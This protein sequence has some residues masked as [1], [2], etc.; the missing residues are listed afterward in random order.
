MQPAM[1]VSTSNS[2]PNSFPRQCVWE[3]GKR[4]P[5]ARGV[6]NTRTRIETGCTDRKDSL[7]EKIVMLFQRPIIRLGEA[8][9]QLLGGV[10]LV[11]LEC[12]HRKLKSAKQPQ[13]RLSGGMDP[14]FG[15]GLKHPLKGFGIN[16]VGSEPCTNLLDISTQV[17]LDGRKGCR[18]EDV[19]ET[20]VKDERG[21]AAKD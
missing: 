3:H 18:T 16:R 4:H 11:E 15:F 21:M 17:R 9:M 14:L 5:L 13:K 10:S 6:Y 1:R 20:T 19:W 2:F 12:N 8:D 7:D